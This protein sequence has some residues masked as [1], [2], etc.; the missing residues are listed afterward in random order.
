MLR[1]GVHLGFVT[2]ESDH[3]PPESGAI[4]EAWRND[5]A[6]RL[7]GAVGTDSFRGKIA[8]AR[9][10]M[11]RVLEGESPADVFTDSPYDEWLAGDKSG[12]YFA[13]VSAIHDQG[14][15]QEIE[16]VSFDAEA[17]G[18]VL[19]E[20]L[21][22]KA[23]WLSYHE[24]DASLR[25]RFSFGMEDH[26]DVAAQPERQQWSARLCDALFP[27]SA[28]VVANPSIRELLGKVLGGEPAFVE[29][30][31]YFNAPNGGAQFHHDVERG[32]AGVIYAQM[33]GNTFWL[34]LNK[35]TLMDEII[36]FAN[37][38][39]NAD[40]I[41][42][43]LPSADDQATLQGL[44]D[45]RHELSDYMEALDHELIEA[46]IDRSPTF[47]ARLIEQ[48]YAHIL[49]PGDAMLLPQRNLD[50]CVWHSVICLGDEPGEGLSFA[51]RR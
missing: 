30:I 6:V 46:L 31:V 23:S 22:C 28:A 35:Q 49:Q 21:W 27:E 17:N 8:Q 32:H 25:F 48:G 43:V 34:A 11:E 38:P 7:A 26:E 12:A 36:S 44:A 10:L 41:A 5:E 3:H 50:T 24:D 37:N 20:D 2:G 16:K 13:L 4:V 1:R 45:E 51:L 40:A 29:R 39:A 18:G 42:Q 19:A 14:D 33:S 15:P 9:K 47:T